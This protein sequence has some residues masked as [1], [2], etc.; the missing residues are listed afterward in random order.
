MV[1]ENTRETQAAYNLISNNCQ[2]YAL[3]LLD[4]IKADG[5]CKFPT[6]NDVYSRLFGP[7]KVM[8]LFTPMEGTEAQGQG[9]ENA[10]SAAENIMAHETTQLDAHMPPVPVQEV[11][12]PQAEMVDA[13]VAGETRERGEV[14]GEENGEESKEGKKKPGFFARMLRKKE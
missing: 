7:G 9:G 1:I 3:R 6:T 13:V 14:D 4:A 8:D 11:P 2:T 10:V 5:D 12:Q